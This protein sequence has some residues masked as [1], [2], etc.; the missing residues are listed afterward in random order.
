MKRHVQYVQPAGTRRLKLQFKAIT[1]MFFIALVIFV[2][3][4]G[5]GYY[6]LP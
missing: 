2:I 3:G 5:L 4:I 6:Y 1:G